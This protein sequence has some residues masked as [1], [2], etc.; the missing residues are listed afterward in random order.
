MSA[1]LLYSDRPQKTIQITINQVIVFILAEIL[2][3]SFL[4]PQIGVFGRGLWLSLPCFGLLCIIVF[5]SRAKLLVW[6][7]TR[8]IVPLLCALGFLGMGLIR[9]SIDPNSE[10]LQ[11][12]VVGGAIC[13]G[14]WFS[15]IM[16]KNVFAE[17]LDQIRWISLIIFG[18]SLGLGIPLLL[19]QPG[20]ARLTMGNI[21]EAYYINIF[22]PQGVTNYNWYTPAAF[23]WPV[24]ANWLYRSRLGWIKKAL[25]WGALLALS[26]AIIL[27]TFTM[28]MIILL[29]GFLAWL[30]F[31]A[32]SSKNLVTLSVIMIALVLIFVGF[33]S[34]YIMG[35]DFAPTAFAVDKATKLFTGLVET[36]SM[37]DSD[38][39]IRTVLFV[40]TMQ[41]FVQSPVLGAWAVLP[42]GF[43]GGHSSWADTLALQGIV[44]LLL[45]LGF[46]SPAWL[47]RGSLL[48]GRGNL[49]GTLSWI[50][51]AIGGTLNPTFYSGLGLMLLWLFDDQGAGY[52]S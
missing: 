15:V 48:S 42:D 16:V 47:G 18:V 39:T 9:Y 52:K 21:N 27:S 45:W 6:Q 28:A 13:F 49:G 38:P 37:I 40:E 23:A 14:L 17:I 31:M 20:V 8:K 51:W 11:K 36:S 33:S 10:Y 24:M 29:V 12:Y 44:G 35:R 7:I 22:F 43:A 50:L 41:T 4:S 2:F 3:A 46:L 19:A 25:G 32:L 26:I 1:K 30:F 5:L 34:L